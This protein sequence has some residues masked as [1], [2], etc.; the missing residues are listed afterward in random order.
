MSLSGRKKGYCNREPLP[1]E[2]RK[3]SRATP[4]KPRGFQRGPQAPLA[5]PRA[6]ELAAAFSVFAA[7]KTNAKR[8]FR[9]GGPGTGAMNRGRNRIAADKG[10]HP[11]SEATKSCRAGTGF[12]PLPKNV[13][14]KAN[15]PGGR[16]R[17]PYR[18][19]QTTGQPQTPRDARHHHF[20]FLF[21]NFSFLQGTPGSGRHR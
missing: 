7:G 14:T 4:L 15:G 13:K 11:A 20:S 2:E 3:P 6:S 1:C 18:V 16:E 17:P 10:R 19:R 8:W 5:V 12:A 9:N 21:F